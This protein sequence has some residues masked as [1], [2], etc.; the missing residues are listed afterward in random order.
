MTVDV[1][2]IGKKS[3]ARVWPPGETRGRVSS[4]EAVVVPEVISPYSEPG[5]VLTVSWGR[6]RTGAG[7]LILG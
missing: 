6:R 1:R 7:C 2:E 3:L 5:S 4:G